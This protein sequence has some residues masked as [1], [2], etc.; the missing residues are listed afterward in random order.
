MADLTIGTVGVAGSGGTYANVQGGEAITKGQP[1]YL[2][3]G[4][5]YVADANSTEAVALVVAVS[6]TGCAT[7]GYLLVAKTGATIDLGATLVVGTEYVLS[8]T[9]GIAPVGDLATGWWVTKLGVAS[10]AA[11]LLLDIKATGI[12]VP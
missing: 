7:D 2:L 11:I 4:K 5:Y 1:L 12:A 8:A 3:T 10:G 9:Q 6:I